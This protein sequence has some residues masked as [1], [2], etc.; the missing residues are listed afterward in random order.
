[1]YRDSKEQYNADCLARATLAK[2]SACIAV[3]YRDSV[4][5]R[6]RITTLTGQLTGCDCTSTITRTWYR[7]FSLP[8]QFA[9]RSELANRTLADSLPCAFA[10]WPFRS[11]E[12]SL[13]GTFALWLFRSGHRRRKVCGNGG[14]VRRSGDSRGAKGAEVERH[15]IE[16]PKVQ[17]APREVGCGE[18]TVPLPRNFFSIFKL[19][20]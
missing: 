20:T 19:K 15:R 16:A 12:L 3:Y 11:L 8:G 6:N 10:P 17:S 7:A 4:R 1:M 14:K 13:P 9:P 18:G 5:T 2:Q